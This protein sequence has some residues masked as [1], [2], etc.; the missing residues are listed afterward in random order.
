MGGCGVKNTRPFLNARNEALLDLPCNKST[1]AFQRHPRQ[2]V[3]L[4]G[5]FRMHVAAAEH[6]E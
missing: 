5:G 1:R 2:P 4:N 6:S 3:K